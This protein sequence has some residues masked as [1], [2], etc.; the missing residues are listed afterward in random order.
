MVGKVLMFVIL[1]VVGGGAFYKI[2]DN[3]FFSIKGSTSAT[4]RDVW[5]LVQGFLF[6]LYAG[7]LLWYFF[8]R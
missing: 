3:I 1:L 8:I 7:G 4:G 2:S 5:L 6:L